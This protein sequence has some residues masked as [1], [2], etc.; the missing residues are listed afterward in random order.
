MGAASLDPAPHPAAPSPACLP[1]CEGGLCPLC[2]VPGVLGTREPC[3]WL[4][5]LAAGSSCH[6]RG[7]V[8]RQ[9]TPP[10]LRH[11]GAHAE[12]CAMIS[13]FTRLWDQLLREGKLAQIAMCLTA[14]CRL[15][16][17]T[18]VPPSVLGCPGSGHPEGEPPP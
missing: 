7:L 15:L 2:G 4:P 11:R 16:A 8:L 13:V 10:G 5:A 6:G 9:P 3:S 1:V 12:Q 18:S 17:V 14:H